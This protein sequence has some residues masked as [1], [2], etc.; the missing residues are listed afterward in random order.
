YSG[1]YSLPAGSIIAARGYFLVVAAGYKGAVT[2]D[3]N[4]GT[5]LSMA[6][7]ATGGGHVRIGTAAMGNTPADTNAV[8]TV[9]YGTGDSPEGSPAP[10]PP[11]AA[12]SYERK[13]KADST[14]ASM[15]GG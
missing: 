14:A 5:A 9:G 15:E 2:G 11:A 6:A 12:S 13:A 1:S 3:A 7:G 4:W 10:A 8:D